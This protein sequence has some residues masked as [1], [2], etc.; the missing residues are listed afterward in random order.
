MQALLSEL[1]QTNKTNVSLV[2]YGVSSDEAQL[3]EGLASLR[4]SANKFSL[5]GKG[6]CD[7]VSVC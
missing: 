6:T 1:K 2:L 7:S 4:S 5:E 3:P